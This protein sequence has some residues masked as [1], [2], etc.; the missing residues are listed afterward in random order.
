MNEK[1]RIEWID[2]AKV[3]GIWLVVLGH[4]LNTGRP[5]EYEL[6][7]IIYSYHMPF[8]FLVS[9][10]LFSTKGMAFGQFAWTKIKS[11]IVPYIL[12]NMLCA[13]LSIPLYIYPEIF[14][15]T[16]LQGLKQDLLTLIDGEFGSIF[17][18]PSWFLITLF[19]VTTVH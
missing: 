8:F 4:I 14:P 9:G 12:L 18:Q 2:Y 17:A 15:T 1:K 19:C 6:H 13:V 11:L 16:E 3:V 7:T 5:I 10:L